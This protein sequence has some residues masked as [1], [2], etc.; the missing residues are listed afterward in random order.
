[1]YV[2]L[3]NDDDTLYG[4]HK[5]R[6]VQRQ[7]LVNDLVFIVDPIYRNVHDMTNASVMLEYVLPVSREYK[8]V[9]L[10]LSEERYNDCY[11]QYK[12]PFDTD[13]TSQAGALELQLTF[14]Y[15]EMTPNGV[16]IQRVRKTSST[17][18]DIVPLTAWSDIVPDSALSGLDQRLIKLDAQ[19]RGLN[20]YMNILDSNKVDNLVYNKRDDTLQLS[21]NG[22]GVGNKVSVRDMIDDGIP[23][24]DLDSGSNDD[25]NLDHND[26]CNCGCDCGE[27]VVEFGNIP[28]TDMPDES[29]DGV[30]E[31]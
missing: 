2:I 22:V 29:D 20:D 12:L 11:L 7:K 9:I 13:I 16:G 30:V 17:T 23:V 14:A 4:S 1:L 26:D 25:S 31:F 24:I 27:N 19:M 5:E 15:V 18:I 3:V 28:S 21:A 6:I 10:T 8:T